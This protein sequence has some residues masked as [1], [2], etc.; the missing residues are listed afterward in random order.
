MNVCQE[1]EVGG[2]GWSIVMEVGGVSID[3]QTIC[4]IQVGGSVNVVTPRKTN[5]ARTY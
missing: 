3:P 5:T 4:L 2:G 1:F